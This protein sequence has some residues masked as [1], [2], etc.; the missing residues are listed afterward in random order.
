L[1][2]SSKAFETIVKRHVFSALAALLALND[3]AATRADELIE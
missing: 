1:P 2:P 3:S